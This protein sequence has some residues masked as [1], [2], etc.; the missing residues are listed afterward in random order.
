M[1]NWLQGHEPAALAC[2]LRENR[3]ADIQDNRQL[4]LL[5]RRRFQGFPDAYR[6]KGPLEAREQ[7]IGNAMHVGLI[8]AIARQIKE[9]VF[10][11]FIVD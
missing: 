2:K 10:A 3:Q 11:G 5:E 8:A 4:S 9:D 6:L 1:P 7:M